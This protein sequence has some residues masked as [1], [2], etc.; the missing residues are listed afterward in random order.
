MR[1]AGLLRLS[2]RAADRWIITRNCLNTGQRVSGEYWVVDS[3]RQLVTVY[4]F[5]KETMEQYSF[6]DDV[7]V[8][9][10]EDFG[11]EGIRIINAL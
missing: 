8:G 4:N 10:Y 1:L 9:I 2:R 11:G 3:E 6:G 5:E 7:P